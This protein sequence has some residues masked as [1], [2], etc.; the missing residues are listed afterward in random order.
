[1]VTLRVIYSTDG[2]RP[3]LES[4]LD[5]VFVADSHR[6]RREDATPATHS[7]PYHVVYIEDVNTAAYDVERGYRKSPSMTSQKDRNTEL[8][9]DFWVPFRIEV[10]Q[11]T[12][13][14][15][16]VR[17]AI[18]KEDLRTRVD[19]QFRRGRFKAKNKKLEDEPRSY[20]PTAL[21]FD[22]LKILA[23]QHPYEGMRY[24]AAILGCS[25]STVSN[26]L[27]SLGMVKK[28]E[29]ADSIGWT[30]LSV[31]MKNGEHPKFDNFRLLHDNARP[32]VAKKTS[33]KILEL[34]LDPPYS[35]D[36]APSD[37][38]LFRSLQHHLEDKRYDDCDDLESDLRAFFVSK[39]PE[40]CAKGIRDLD[41]RRWQK[42]VDV[43]GDYFV[44]M[45]ELKKK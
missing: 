9:I 33:Q 10:E 2:L 28:L 12:W 31:E 36:L 15:M 38:H 25:M 41:V 20:R 27:R 42:V 16:G 40:F 37:Y 30:P 26:G 11:S 5:E 24:F 39:S 43:D 7:Y 17:T 23:E 18:V 35:P 8:V 13:S 6:F 3:V 21:S 44:K 32:H 1:M 34:S 19:K 22:E 45:N 14:K 4:T 29:A